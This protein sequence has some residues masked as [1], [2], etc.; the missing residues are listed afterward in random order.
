MKQCLSCLLV[1]ELS[2][3][4]L[5]TMAI[6]HVVTWYPPLC[7]VAHNRVDT[8]TGPHLSRA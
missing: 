7:V 1:A 4:S 5:V 3:R 8:C 6:T 2:V